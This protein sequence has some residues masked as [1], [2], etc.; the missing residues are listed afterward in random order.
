ML[1]KTNKNEIDQ[2]MVVIEDGR[3]FLKEQG[4][5][6]WQHGAPGRDD[7]E[8][9]LKLGTS[10]VYEVDGVITATAMLNNYDEDYE[11][12]NEIWTPANKYLVVHRVATLEKYRSQ[13]IGKKFMSAI[14]D[15][16]RSQNVDF[17]RIDTHFD[18]K[19]M[20]KFLSNFGFKELGEIKL[21]MKNSLDD[22]ERVAYE[23]KV[24]K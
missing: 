6:Q 23:Y 17:V 21:N 4:I 7:V 11:K 2:V 12:Y 13:G 22:K 5:N 24:E 1:R 9:D 18:N 16:A 15:Y 14:I 8:N 10:Y 3:S 19:I 20:R